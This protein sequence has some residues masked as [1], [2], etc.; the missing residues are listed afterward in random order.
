[1]P[2]KDKIE[3]LQKDYTIR[4]FGKKPGP[5]E[6]KEQL[7]N[8]DVKIYS[9]P[10]IKEFRKTLAI[11]LLNTWNDKPTMDFS[12]DDTYLQMSVQKINHE[13]VMDAATYN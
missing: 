9:A 6:F 13:V 12:E 3:N 7:S 4:K 2:K 11:F 1:M 5:I 10:S 8:I